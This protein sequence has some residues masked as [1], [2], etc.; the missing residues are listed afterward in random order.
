LKGIC[1][2]DVVDATDVPRIIPN[3]QEQVAA[4][5]EAKSQG[6]S[7]MQQ[8]HLR[9]LQSSGGPGNIRPRKV[10]EAMSEQQNTEI[11]PANDRAIHLSQMPINLSVEQSMISDSHNNTYIIG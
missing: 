6:L 11:K 4:V 7:N 5:M 1:L 10:A 2:D 9:S 3:G 8:E